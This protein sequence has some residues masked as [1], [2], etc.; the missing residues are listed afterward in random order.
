VG[1]GLPDFSWHNIPNG[2]EIYQIATKLPNGHKIYQMSRVYSKCPQNIS[3]FSIPRP[4]NIYPNWYFWFENLPSGNPDWVLDEKKTK[5][6][7]ASTS[8]G[9][10]C[11]DKPSPPSS[12]G[13]N[14][15]VN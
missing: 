11:T 8:S 3:N 12:A 13:D 1:L 9:K 15:N 2:E 5:N 4:S 7:F 14:E 6:A 10:L